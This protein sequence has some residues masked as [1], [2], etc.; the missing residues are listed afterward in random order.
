MRSVSSAPNLVSLLEGE[1][2]SGDEDEAEMKVGDDG[3]VVDYDASR[4]SRPVG[5][6]ARSPVGDGGDDPE[7]FDDFSVDVSPSMWFEDPVR[8][9]AFEAGVKTF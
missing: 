1:K 4:P 3:V 5:G 8:G 2:S 9:A 6:A 7:D